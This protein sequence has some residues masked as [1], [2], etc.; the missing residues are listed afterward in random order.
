[1]SHKFE[2]AEVAFLLLGILVVENILSALNLVQFV[3]LKSLSHLNIGCFRNF[4]ISPKCIVYVR[5]ITSKR[6][7]H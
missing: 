1:M 7:N 5:N 3:K 6:F 2:E 4:V